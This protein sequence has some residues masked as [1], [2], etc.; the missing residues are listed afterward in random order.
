MEENRD[1][2]ISAQKLATAWI[3]TRTAREM[4]VFSDIVE[5]T[6]NI[7]KEA[8]ARKDFLLFKS[9]LLKLKEVQFF[10]DSLIFLD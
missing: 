10:F 8:K 3:E 9:L 4:E 7:I 1:K 2:I 6:H 5:I